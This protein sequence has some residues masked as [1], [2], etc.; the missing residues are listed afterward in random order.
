MR[1][2][3]VA[4]IG[5]VGV[6]AAGVLLAGG[7]I[8]LEG[9]T[10]G[11]SPTPLPPVPASDRVVAEAR[12]IP[13]RTAE[14][15]A[16]VP[17]EVARVAVAEGDVVVAG[18]L[19]LAL[20]STTADANVVAAKAVL[21][22]ADAG[23]DQAAAAERQAAAEVNRAKAVLDGAK[24]ARD[25][26]PSGASKAQKRAADAQISTAR[27]GIASALAAQDGLTAAAVAAGAD[28]A[29]AASL[30]TAAQAAAS[31]LQLTAPFAGTVAAVD[32]K[33]GDVVA[34]GAPLIR[35]A[36]G[37]WT[38]QTTDLGQ[39]GVA[40]IAVGNAATVTVDGF[41]GSPVP[42][43]VTRIASVGADSQGDV[44]FTVVVEPTGDVPDGLRWNM[45]ASIQIAKR[46]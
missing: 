25:Q 41:G 31:A 11:S 16:A 8:R 24:A 18:A 40:A 21:D 22:A 2:W 23:A 14:I 37:G 46:P 4:G 5:V 28:R 13:A 30:L 42:A 39:D 12:A 15:G 45:K 26:V 27:A 3:L 7:A 43:R 17:G 32:A 29:R 36:S 35:M 33:D 34:A 20:D 9:S 38:F 44:V 1:R 6:L 19:L 10:A